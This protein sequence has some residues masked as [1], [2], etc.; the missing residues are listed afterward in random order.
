MHSYVWTARDPWVRAQHATISEWRVLRE[1]RAPEPL[2]KEMPDL[3]APHTLH[4]HPPA[5]LTS[6]SGDRT[7][8]SLP[9]AQR[10]RLRLGPHT[11]DKSLDFLLLVPFHHHRPHP[12]PPFRTL[13]SAFSADTLYSG[14]EL[15]SLNPRLSESAGKPSETFK[16]ESP[17]VR[18]EA[19][20]G[21]SES[22]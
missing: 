21:P 20:A 13:L 12:H 4:P 5:A 10:N 18:K 11:L 3:P 2:P 14:A 17:R 8:E 19:L 1:V 15:P 9:Q 7:G 6:P 22:C 16:V